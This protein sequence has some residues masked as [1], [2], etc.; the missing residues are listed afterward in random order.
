MALTFILNGCVGLA[1]R[2]SHTKLHD[3]TNINGKNIY[4]GQSGQAVEQLLGAPDKSENASTYLGPGSFTNHNLKLDVSYNW[5]YGNHVIRIK[6]G[7]VNSIVE[8]NVK[9][10]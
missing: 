1:E 5:T 2:L 9:Y 3:K 7:V 4:V 6:D 8:M 10:E